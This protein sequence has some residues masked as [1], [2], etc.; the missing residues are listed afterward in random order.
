MNI[1]RATAYSALTPVLEQIRK[2]AA[3]MERMEIH[4]RNL[5]PGD[6]L[7]E[8]GE[9]VRQVFDHV[10]GVGFELNSHM[11]L[12]QTTQV[13]GLTVVAGEFVK[14]FRPVQP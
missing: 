14:I 11:V 6:I 10:F 1:N 2:D 3:S 7:V 9:T 13:S 4:V 5:Q 8:S 12:V